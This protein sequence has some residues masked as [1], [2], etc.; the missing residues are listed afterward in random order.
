MISTPDM[1]GKLSDLWDGPYEV[2]RKVSPVVY[3]LA[4]PSRRSKTLV[5]HVNRLKAWKNPEAH[6]LRV[7]MA[8]E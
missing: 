6:V 5:A 4:V 3:E 7:V 1:E 2:I 8:E